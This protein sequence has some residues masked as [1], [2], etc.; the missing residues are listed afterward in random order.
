M[1]SPLRSPAQ[2]LLSAEAQ[3]SLGHILPCSGAALQPGI[4]NSPILLCS[5]V[6]MKSGA[7]GT[8]VR[9]Q[10]LTLPKASPSPWTASP[11]PLPKEGLGCPQ[12]LPSYVLSKQ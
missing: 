2:L 10:A 3:P 5:W 1:P 4:T 7:S 11:L 6:P 9:P 12:A 8:W